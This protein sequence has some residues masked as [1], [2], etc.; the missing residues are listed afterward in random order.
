MFQAL[1]DYIFH[2]FNTIDYTTVFV[3]MVLEASVF[4]VP[5]EIP[6]IAIGIQSANGTMN[7]IIGILIGLLGIFIGTSINYA[8]G[9]Y[10][11]DAFVEK[12]GKYFFIKKASYHHAQEL[13]Q[14]D[15]D[16]YTFFGRLVPVVRHLISIPAGM[17]HMPYLRFIT[18]SLSGSAIWLGILVTLGY[19]IGDNQEL[20]HQYTLGITI[21]IIVV[22]GIVWYIQ[23]RRKHTVIVAY[24][25]RANASI[26]K[27]LLNRERK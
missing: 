5:S 13:F 9:Y 10:I 22:G 23:H 2:F 20:I 17:A 14:K 3:M 15:A 24:M 18:L 12:Y 27:W 26:K 6:M 4:P 1:Y 8:I 11:G 25:L 7:P 21:T 16:F 19:F